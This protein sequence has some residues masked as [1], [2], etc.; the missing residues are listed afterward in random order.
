MTEVATD[1]DAARPVLG[2]LAV[3]MAFWG[4][5]DAVNAAAAPFIAREFGLDDS[6]IAWTFGFMALG[7]L[8]FAFLASCSLMHQHRS[9]S[10]S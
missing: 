10:H 3:L 2:T 1:A 8:A 4:Y 7:A 9:R 6:G 5:A